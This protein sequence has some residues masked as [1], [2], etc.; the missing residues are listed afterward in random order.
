MGQTGQTLQGVLF[1]LDGLL[2]DS[3]PL[4]FEVERAVM[5]RLGGD[6]TEHDQRALVGGSLRKSVDYLI[7]RARP[8]PG[9]RVPG[10]DEVA[11]WL[12]SG[13][14][15]TLASREV[16]PLPGAVEL[17]TAVRA[18]GLPYALVTSSERVIVDAV[19]RTL[20][21]HDVSFEVI[22]S[23]ADVRHPK[24]DPEPYRLAAALLGAD[25]ACCVALE[26]S[27]N[28][29]ASARAAGCATVA[30]PGLAS[31]P[32]SA[33]ALVLRSLAELDVAALHALI[34]LARLGVLLDEGPAGQPQA[35]DRQ[36]YGHRDALDHDRADEM[37][38]EGIA[39]G[40]DDVAEGS[41][42]GDRPE[43]VRA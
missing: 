42:L 35:D 22:V 23:G 2:V 11:Q 39:H 7:S 43:P 9:Q 34:G 6:W 12:L 33:G 8:R 32:D 41:R 20:A 29:V 21:R 37:P 40:A 26:D 19:L 30:V 3:E 1:D 4:W 38:G 17:V 5:A 10:H 31:I 28:G 18:A 24:P 25:P 27:P 13:M 36:A 16:K 15:Q 14:A